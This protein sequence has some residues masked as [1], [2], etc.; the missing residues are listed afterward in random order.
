MSRVWQCNAEGRLIRH[1]TAWWNR[2][3]AVT[4]IRLRVLLKYGRARQPAR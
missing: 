1:S 3:P 2:L 4:G